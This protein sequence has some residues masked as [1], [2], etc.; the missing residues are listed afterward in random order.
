[1][2]QATELNAVLSPDVIRREKC[3]ENK[4]MRKITKEKEE[5]GRYKEVLRSRNRKEPKL[6]A[7]AVAVIKCLAPATDQPQK[8]P[9]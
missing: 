3:K 1:V 6:V 5:R 8:I 7:G 4:K 9:L 2:Q